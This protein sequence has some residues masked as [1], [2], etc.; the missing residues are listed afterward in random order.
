MLCSTV[1][2]SECQEDLK[3]DT[4]LMRTDKVAS[5]IVTLSEPNHSLL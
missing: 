2:K 5:W 3:N 1:N 4:S